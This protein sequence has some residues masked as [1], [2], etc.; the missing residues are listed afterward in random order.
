MKIRRGETFAHQWQLHFACIGRAVVSSTLK[1]QRGV[2]VGKFVPDR[3]GKRK[4]KGIV[5]KKPARVE[6]L[7]SASLHALQPPT[8]STT[9]AI[10]PFPPTGAEVPE[11]GPNFSL[12]QEKG[13][14][15][16]ERC[17]IGEREG[18]RSGRNWRSNILLRKSLRVPRK[19]LSRSKSKTRKRKFIGAVPFEQKSLP[20][21]LSI[22][23]SESFFG[24]GDGMGRE[25][26]KRTSV[27][28]HVGWQAKEGGRE[29]RAEWWS[30][31]AEKRR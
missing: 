16:R 25:G 20:S 1:Q 9:P 7:R 31:R 19:H 29:V 4:R 3:R 12:F 5:A 13:K 27:S 22:S 14:R 21:P 30:I 28:N 24:K 8:T 26:G 18:A 17:E 6:G 15:G 2:K 11:R 23:P 10:E